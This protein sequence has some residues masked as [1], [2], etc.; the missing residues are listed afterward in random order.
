MFI[1]LCNIMRFDTISSNYMPTHVSCWQWG[2]MFWPWSSLDLYYTYFTV[3][4]LNLLKFFFMNGYQV[5]MCMCAACSISAITNFYFETRLYQIFA[6]NWWIMKIH[7]EPNRLPYV[8][9]DSQLIFAIK[10]PIFYGPFLS[11]QLT[12]FSFSYYHSRID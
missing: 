3:L 8:F 5:I 4:I 9:V 11:F 12:N 10:L 1:L 6:A 7:L 2:Q